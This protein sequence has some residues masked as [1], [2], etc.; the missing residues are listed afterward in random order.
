MG[1]FLT[2]TALWGYPYL[3]RAQGRSG[4]A[5]GAL[6]ALAVVAFAVAAPSAGWVASRN[7]LRDPILLV[8]SVAVVVVWALVMG[9]PGGQL[10]GPLLLVLLIVTGIGGAVSLLAFDVAR[11][12][13][14]PERGGRATAFV[15]LGGFGFAVVAAFLV[16]A[17]LDLQHAAGSDTPQAFRLAFVLVLAMAGIG[18]IQ[19]VRLRPR[20]TPGDR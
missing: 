8:T 18:L 7:G 13:N 3:V 19:V 1:P 12:A 9:W 4:S 2:F 16:G 14:P 5:A 17:V 11:E 15:N 10:P 6:L 20:P